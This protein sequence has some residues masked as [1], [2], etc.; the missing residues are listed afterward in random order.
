MRQ[1]AS[2]PTSRAS[3]EANMIDLRKTAV[4]TVG[5]KACKV[6]RVMSVQEQRANEIGSRPPYMYTSLCPDERYRRP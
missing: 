6:D 2:T 4:Y 3:L 1:T 5:R